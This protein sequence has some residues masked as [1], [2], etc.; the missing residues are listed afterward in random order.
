MQNCFS[1][2]KPSSTIHDQPSVLRDVLAVLGLRF[3]IVFEGFASASLAT[4]VL[5]AGAAVSG[6]LCFTMDAA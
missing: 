3:D 6:T 1:S 4:F 2:L 5:L